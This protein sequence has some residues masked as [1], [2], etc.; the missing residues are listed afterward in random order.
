MT[1]AKSKFD[2][3]LTRCGALIL[4][5]SQMK[6]EHLQGRSLVEPSDDLLRAS[7]VLA[8]AAFDAYATDCFTEKFI[9]FVKQHGI[10]A[11]IE[12]LL[13]DSGFDIKFAFELLSAKRPYRKVRT[14]IDHHYATYVTEKLDVIDEL[15]LIYGLQNITLNAARRSGRD[16]DRILNRVRSLVQRRHS[17]AHD[18]DYDE[19]GHLKRIS[20]ADTNKINDLR[21]LVE[22]MDEI[23]ESRF[24]RR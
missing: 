1:K 7:I 8:V 10:S 24:R 22:N 20:A 19:H 2:N 15:F 12:E 4:G 3:T 13:T 16:P 14:L 9:D 23:I 17:I 11:Q 6:E 18:G 5:Y 21:L